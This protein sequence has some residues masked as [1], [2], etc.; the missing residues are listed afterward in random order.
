MSIVSQIIWT[1]FSFWKAN[2]LLKIGEEAIKYYFD[3]VKV[4]FGLWH[5]QKES[6]FVIEFGY[7]SSDDNFDE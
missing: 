6:L 4:D 3:Q 5:W 1:L 2:I 7:P